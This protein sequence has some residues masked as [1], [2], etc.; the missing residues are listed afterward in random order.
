MKR[1][2]P[3]ASSPRFRGNLRHYHRSGGSEQSSWDEWV[4]GRPRRRSG[5][6]KFLGIVLALLALVAVVVGLFV[7]LGSG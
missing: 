1:V 4:D 2:E 6:A 5:R 7:E 3:S